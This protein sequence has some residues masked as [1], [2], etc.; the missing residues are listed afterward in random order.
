MKILLLED[1]SKLSSHLT[2]VFSEQGWQVLAAQSIEELETSL[3]SENDFDLLVLDRLIGRQDS[4]TKIKEIKSKAPQAKILIL[5]SI[6]LPEERAKWI[7]L[8]V[9]EYMG[10][11]VFSEE[12]MARVRLLFRRT[13]DKNEFLKIGTLII[14][15]IKRQ[16]L[17]GEKRLQLT[18][19]EYGLLLILAES[20]G[21]VFS[22]VQLL[23]ILWDMDSSVE[24]NV[25]ESTVNHLRRKLEE[26]NV[27]SIIKSRRNF[28]YWIEN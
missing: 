25:V 22:K 27:E 3:L 26:A 21:R 12:L 7:N 23:E 24:S 17:A 6:N 5:S 11:P 16:V 8:G 18:S 19:K 9:D 13:T 14:D 1:D 2:K 20:P 28:G 10:K 4:L 15:K